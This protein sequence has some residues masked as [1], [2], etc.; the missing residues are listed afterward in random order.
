MTSSV[1]AGRFDV[2]AADLSLTPAA[3][4]N[5]HGK[6]A[7]AGSGTPT[8]GT[9]A[10]SNNGGSFAT[11]GV[12]ALTAAA[13]SNQAGTLSAQRQATVTTNS[14][15]LNNTGTATGANVTVNANTITNTGAAAVFAA[16]NQLNLYATNQLTN[17]GSANPCER[18]ATDWCVDRCR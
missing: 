18:P 7:H 12:L 9:G 5:D 3:L 16:A 11:N 4:I 1:H 10:L 13:L 2:C 17:T 14:A 8:I 15:T 6:I